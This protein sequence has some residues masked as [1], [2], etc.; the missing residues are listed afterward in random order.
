MKYLAVLIHTILIQATSLTAVFMLGVDRAHSD[1]IDVHLFFGT[2]DHSPAVLYPG[3]KSCRVDKSFDVIV[4]GTHSGRA[5]GHP[6][7][8]CLIECASSEVF[9]RCF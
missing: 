3:R 1:I 9:V 6:P 7:D 4:S 8:T 5:Q 2:L